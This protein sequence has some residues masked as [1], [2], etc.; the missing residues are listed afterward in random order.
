MNFKTT[1]VLLVLLIAVGGYFFFIEWGKPSGYDLRERQRS[2]DSDSGLGKPVFDDDALTADSIRVIQIDHGGQAVTVTREEDGWYQTAPVR[3]ALEGLIAQEVAR[4]F[5]NL[6][7]VQ[8]LEPGDPATPTTQ[9]MGLDKPRAVVTVHVGDKQWT[10]HLGRLT[11]G[12]RGYVQVD[13]ADTVYVV[14]AFLHGVVLDQPITQWRTKSL[15]LPQAS[16]AEHIELHQK[17]G[18]IGLSKVD[19]RWRFDHQGQG[20]QRASAEAVQDLVLAVGRLGIEKFIADNPDDLVT[21]GLDR[22]T[23]TFVIQTPPPAPTDTYP[24]DQPAAPTTHTLRIGNTD[25]QGAAR[26]AVLTQDGEQASVVFTLNAGSAEA[27]ATTP[28]KLRDPR[29]IVARQQDIRELVVQQDSATTL[30][31]IRDPQQGY[32]YGDPA[33]GYGVDF[34]TANALTQA[35]CSLEST[36]FTTDLTTLGEPFATVQLTLATGDGQVSFSIYNFGED[37]AVVTE[38]ESVGYTVRAS[39]LETLLGTAMGLRDRSVLDL[40]PKQIAAVKLRRDGDGE[41]VFLPTD[42]QP[43]WLLDADPRFEQEDFASLIASLSPLRAQRWLSEQVTP[44]DDWITWT[45]EPVGG[46]PITLR[47]DPADGR[48]TMSG[49]DSAFVLPRPTVEKLN[50][51]YR[52]RT[53]LTMSADQIESVT[54]TGAE[55]GVTITRDGQRFVTDLQ[56]EI[57]QAVAAGVFDTLAGLRA[58]RY[59]RPLHL[60]PEDIDFTIEFKASEDVPRAPAVI[61]FVGMQGYQTT[62]ALDELPVTG[63]MRWFTLS[64][65]DIRKLRAPLSDIETPIK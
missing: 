55:T 21:Y 46:A 4:Q 18:V 49:L 43:G 12:G 41:L 60:R 9:Q 53:V 5:A 29:V 57:D 32:R 48:A 59:V 45:I 38:G 31:L 25:L 44:S 17:D 36:R 1:L 51:E 6:R 62:V 16:G 27:L 50:A 28:D 7:A 26:Y 52:E 35:L 65:E 20:I 3:F 33:P 39:D 11:L 47:V 34:S 8:R 15:N 14:D 23:M 56:G 24:P 2:A 42:E 10:L 40:K 30:N 19:G 37:S 58:E 22:P 63:P 64:P 61:R 54:V 13:G